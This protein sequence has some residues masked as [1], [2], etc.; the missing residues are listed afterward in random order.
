MT[1]YHQ[2][3]RTPLFV[4]LSPHDHSK[5]RMTQTYAGSLFG[6]YLH[7]L[8]HVFLARYRCANSCGVTRC[9]QD[10]TDQHSGHGWAWF[11]LAV[12]VHTMARRFFPSID[13]RMGI[14]NSIL[15]DY[16]TS[17]QV[18]A[19]QL[20]LVIVTRF[21]DHEVDDFLG[22][23]FDF[24]EQALD[25]A[26]Q[27]DPFFG[28]RGLRV[29]IKR[30]Q[31]IRD[32]RLPGWTIENGVITLYHSELAVKIPADESLGDIA[33]DELLR[34]ISYPP[35]PSG[36]LWAPTE[37]PGEAWQE[38]KADQGGQRRPFDCTPWKHTTVG[39]DGKLTKM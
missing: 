36:F 29:G 28:R 7:E 32:G 3:A 11:L 9:Q 18:P 4:L 14:F 20:W 23:M 34:R 1:Q 38:A 6:V 22:E 5:E 19:Y 31:W 15:L 17:K 39:A 2:T 13:V 37:V 16:Q 30:L 33:R 10:R 35:L 26:Y 8:C 25:A 12:H 27:A 21:S 24:Q